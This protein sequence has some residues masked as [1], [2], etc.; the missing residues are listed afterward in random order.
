MTRKPRQARAKSKK[1]S[2]TQTLTLCAL[3][4]E[5]FL[6]LS[7]NTIPSSRLPDAINCLKEV[8]ALQLERCKLHSRDLKSYVKQNKVPKRNLLTVLDKQDKPQR[9]E[10][11]RLA[12]FF[13]HK[14]RMMSLFGRL[15]TNELA[16]V[17]LNCDRAMSSVHARHMNHQAA[18]IM[19]NS[20]LYLESSAAKDD[21]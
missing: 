10:K 15:D 13:T 7:L 4:H 8:T 21:L 6:I 12:R 14:S 5:R 17:L 11:D 9:I 20:M 18:A 19:A 2:D 16:L 3:H 1:L